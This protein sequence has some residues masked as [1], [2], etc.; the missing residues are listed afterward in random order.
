MELSSQKAGSDKER[1]HVNCWWFAF[2]AS[3]PSRVAAYSRDVAYAPT[4]IVLKQRLST[5]S[6]PEGFVCLVVQVVL[7][8]V[9][10]CIFNVPSVC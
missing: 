3:C 2:E 8:K 9:M 6:A 1:T 7:G 4:T 5:H 10:V